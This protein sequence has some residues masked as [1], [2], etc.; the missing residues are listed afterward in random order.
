MRARVIVLVSVFSWMALSAWSVPQAASSQSP[1]ASGVSAATSTAPTVRQFVTQYCTAC[2]NQRTQTG[3]LALDTMDFENL[4]A[5]A[6]VWEKVIR[7]VRVGMMPPAG[8]R[9][10]DAA[11]R[12]AL[13]TSLSSTLDQAARANPNPGRPALHRLNR[14]EY[15]NVI[16]DL[17][18]LEVEARTLLPPDDSAYG[19]DN[20]ADVLGVSATL[21]EQYVSAAG[22]VS[23]LA[24]GDPDV[25]PGAE[26][27][28]IPQ[29]AS[30]DKHVEGLPFG[31]VGG[32]L[33]KPTIQVA[34]QYELS[35]KFFRTNLGVLRGLEYEHWLE[36]SVD[37]ERV[38]L[39]KVGGPDD[40]AANL[41]NN[42]L[43]ADEIEQRAK[44]RVTLTAGPHEIAAAWLKKSGA[45][46]PVRTTRPIRSSH[47][48]RDPMGIPH[49][50]TF[51]IAGPFDPIGSG[52]TASRRRI[53]SCEPTKGVEDRC[54][55]QIISTLVRR[56][57]RGQGTDADVER[58]MGFYRRGHQERDFE[59]GIQVALQRILASP[60]F[61]FRAERD[62]RNAVPGKAYR[63]SDLELASRLSFFL[64]SSIPDDELLQVA[65]EGKLNTPS[66]LERQ[67]R[68]MLAD[69][70]SKRLVANFAGQWLYL[71]NLSNHQPNSMEFPDFDDNLRQSFRRESEM[72]FESIIRE[73]RNVLD[74]M[75]ADY[76]FVDE[77][78]AKHYGIPN[79]YGSHFRRV[80][81]T[82]EARKGLLGKGAILTVTSYATR[83]SPV[84]RG[85]WILDNIL[86]APPPPPPRDIVIP[87]LPE[88]NGQ[89]RIL[90]MRERMEEHRK[91]PICANC[92]RLF[93]PI[94]L[95]M[96]NFD[97]VGEWRTRDGGSLGSPIDASGELLDGTRVDGV[98]SLRQAL[99]RQ[100]ELFVGTVVEKLMTYALGR[101][102]AAHDMPTVRAV[103]RDTARRDYRF[104]AI[105]LGIVNSTPFTMRIG[106]PGNAPTTVATAR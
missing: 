77:R 83:T 78:L 91:N 63:I 31:T 80:N 39:T 30:Q 18:D 90:T 38:H 11:T 68:R 101:G 103:V 79:V 28:R 57:Y 51:T 21:M 5:G 10:P 33:A 40:W 95:A 81:V 47:D 74:L 106:V 62:P 45:S 20:V 82:D 69:P 3:G 1:T 94:G 59:R 85:R 96:E 100:P 76:T 99:L 19:F 54:A 75:T 70:K 46:D 8:V 104:S 97:A 55:R 98:V 93:D 2:H 64:W 72:F 9:H 43:I 36:Y 13:L 86:N 22:K 58:L 27:Y 34:G 17:L 37:G 41:E 7:K 60:K 49:L 29:E 65:S 14:T 102:V 4:P 88:G 56:A 35:A 87:P 50:S 52:D 26:V 16:R 67:V 89:D 73:D 66:G 24:V 48:T 44:A 71:R 15:A 105:V 92:H 53:F 23:S 42:T 6:D 25:S 12:S 61:V 32:I 84:V